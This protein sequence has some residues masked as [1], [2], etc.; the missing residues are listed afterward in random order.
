MRIVLVGGGAMG[1]MFAAQLAQAGND[2]AVLDSSREVV[3]HINADGV[4]VTQ[5]ND[6]SVTKIEATA[7]PAILKASELAIVFVKAHHTHAVAGSLAEHIGR[8]TGVLSLQNGWGNSDTLAAHIRSEQLV[9]GVTYH[10]CTVIGPGQVA[11]TGS[12]PTFIGPYEQGTGLG[13]AEE[14]AAALRAAGLDA[15][16][17]D[18]VRTEIW[19]KLILNA[20]ALPVAATTGLRSA[21][22]LES[23]ETVALVEALALE[24]VAVA[25]KLGMRMVASERLD[26]IY[27]V[28]RGAGKGKPSMLQ[29]IEMRRKTEV[30][31]I[32]GAVV[33]A[34]TECGVAVP[35][36]V[37]MCALVHGIERS[38]A[39]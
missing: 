9:M 37:A 18:E 10:S 33:R 35:L 29:D 12:G 3:N 6:R 16:A 31:V 4:V 39:S 22:M 17:T 7:D 5:G 28:L 20:A 34:G 25:S 27:A 32:N 24:A 23:A 8:G 38:W 1:C 2:V 13:R 14:V 19:N 11:H 21:E 36:N 30:E 15:T 26:R